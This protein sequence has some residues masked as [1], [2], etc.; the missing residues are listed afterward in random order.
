M[1]LQQNIAAPT[2]LTVAKKT[3]ELV[4][5][6]LASQDIAQSSRA[7]YKRSLKSFFMWI[8][9]SSYSLSDLSIKELLIYKASL[10]DSGLSSLTIG[11]YLGAVR[12][13]YEWA[14]ANKLYPNIAR[15]VKNPKRKQQFRKQPLLPAQATELLEY[16]QLHS[17]RDYAIISLLLRTG[18]R[19]IEVSRANIEDIVYKGSKRVLLIQGKGKSEK[20]NFVV[21]NEKAYRPIAIYL[22]TRG[23]VNSSDP[24]FVSTSNN[25]TRERLSTRTI[26]FI[27]KEAL[28]GIGLNEK[29][30]TA[31]SL[32]HT[33][34]T[35]ILRATGDLEKTRLFC[36]HINPATTLIYTATL[37]EERRLENSG[38]DILDTLY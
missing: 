35:N 31:H 8:N 37:N 2:A 27:A 5:S 4:N 16:S 36:R 9:Q 19:T 11:S 26:S 12:R 32:R 25:S 13:F 24:L 38:E 34:A 21:L 10:A 7:V 30:Y 18:L 6:F 29:A 1:Q 33:G 15:G 28:K 23:A 17:P 20:D 3:E 14:E 22:E